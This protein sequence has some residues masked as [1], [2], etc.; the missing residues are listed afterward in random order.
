MD[1]FD[2]LGHLLRIDHDA[3][4]AY[5]QAIDHLH[6]PDLRDVLIRFRADHER[7]VEDL[8]LAIRQMG[9]TPPR[10]A[11]LAGFAL[12]GFTA[13]A[14]GMG[15]NTA[16]MAMQSNEVVTSQAYEL[17]LQTALPEQVRD[18]VKRNMADEQRHL[19]TLRGLLEEGA[20]GGVLLSRSAAL[21]GLGTSMMMN[22]LR[23]NPLATAA[24]ATGAAVLLGRTWLKGPPPGP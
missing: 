11:H 16:L 2:Q 12:A 17:A 21:Q 23:I 4:R 22:V 8:T 9:G 3:I 13:V 7:H 6:D 24:A 18:L 14:S 1:P 5:T 19:A 20:P 15:V 10:T